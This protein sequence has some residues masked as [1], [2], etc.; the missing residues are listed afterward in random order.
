MSRSDH[1][2]RRADTMACAVCSGA[3]CG[4][5]AHEHGQLQCDSSQTA[6]MISGKLSQNYLTYALGGIFGHGDPQSTHTDHP[7]AFP[8][9]K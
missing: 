5:R 3:N 8:R 4:G 1:P 7:D 9:L 2:R 6:S